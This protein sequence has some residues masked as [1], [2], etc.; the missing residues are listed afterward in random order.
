MLHR[1]K[2]HISPLFL[3]LHTEPQHFKFW[4]VYSIM[5]LHS[6]VEDKILNRLLRTVKNLALCCNSFFRILLWTW[7]YNEMLKARFYYSIM[8]LLF[9]TLS[10]SPPG[11]LEFVWVMKPILSKILYS[12]LLSLSN[13]KRLSA[14]LIWRSLIWYVVYNYTRIG[15]LGKNLLHH[16]TTKPFLTTSWIVF[17]QDM[18]GIL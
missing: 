13:R 7:F 10:K 14:N 9:L 4:K 3:N 12:H 11:T 17:I 18:F 16:S 6:F 2:A 15:H 8:Y 1:E 5:K